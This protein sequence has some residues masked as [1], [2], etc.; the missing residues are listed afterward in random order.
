MVV[1]GF[2]LSLLFFGFGMYLLYKHNWDNG[3]FKDKFAFMGI[4]CLI[5]GVILFMACFVYSLVMSGGVLILI[6]LFLSILLLFS[7]LGIFFFQ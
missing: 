5:I 7:G 3:F 2:L 4:L 6:I 1:L